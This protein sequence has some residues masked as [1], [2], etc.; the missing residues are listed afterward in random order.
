[1][2][3]LTPRQA[4]LLS[5]WEK[6][7][8]LQYAMRWLRKDGLDAGYCELLLARAPETSLALAAHGVCDQ[9]LPFAEAL[10]LPA[11]DRKQRLFELELDGITT[12]RAAR[13]MVRTEDLELLEAWVDRCVA[14]ERPVVVAPS[15]QRVQSKV[16]GLGTVIARSGKTVTVRFDSGE[17][18]KLGATFVDAIE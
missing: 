9:L 3:E 2:V 18:K 11:A 16:F 14:V 7:D 12:W 6:S 17:T 5:H 8:A 4:A 15:D 13:P 10:K 1:M